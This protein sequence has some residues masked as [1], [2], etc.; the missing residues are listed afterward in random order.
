MNSKR[1]STKVIVK[2][3][4]QGVSFRASLYEKATHHK[5]DGWVRNREDGSVEALLQGDEDSVKM[6]VEW[7]R[8]GPPRA[9]VSAVTE[10]L[11]PLHPRQKGFQIVR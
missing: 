8:L 9:K 10:E 5:V 6:V 1:V 3:R 2:G 11:L 7:A 4:V